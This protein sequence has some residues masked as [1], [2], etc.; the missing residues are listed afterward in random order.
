MGLRIPSTEITYD[1]YASNEGFP[2]LTVTE[3]LGIVTSAVYKDDPLLGIAKQEPKLI[4]RVYPNPAHNL[5]NIES[6]HHDVQITICDLSGKT[7]LQNLPLGTTSVDISSLPSGVY[8]L[9]STW[10][11]DTQW[12]KFMKQ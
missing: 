10:E 4:S 8:L 11:T 5:L 3:Q 9:K 6:P 2:V 1:W 7:V 12:S